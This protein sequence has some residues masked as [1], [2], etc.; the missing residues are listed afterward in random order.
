MT[1][2]HR[3]WV[4]ATLAGGTLFALGIR[5][6]FILRDAD[7]GRARNRARQL[8]PTRIAAGVALLLRPQLLAGALGLSTGQ[9]AHWLPRLLAVR[10]IALGIG[11]VASS[12]G[13]AD[14]WP[15]LMTI[16]AVDGAEAAVLA[17]ALRQR[18]VDPAGGWA[19][20]AADLGSASAVVLR[21]A[22]LGAHE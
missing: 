20:T 8:G 2:S 6:G 22:R 11:A 4:V 18:A 21:V 9:A 12:R 14:P 10:E 13:D 15:W 1:D 5:E 16:A 3:R 19:F 17:A 7:V